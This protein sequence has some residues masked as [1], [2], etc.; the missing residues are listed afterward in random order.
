MSGHGKREK[1]LKA[2]AARWR[3]RVR[4]D[5]ASPAGCAAMSEHKL[6]S[7]R[8]VDDVADVIAG[9]IAAGDLLVPCQSV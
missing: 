8:S 9:H 4:A 2:D 1:I 6:L 7:V 5:L 3:S